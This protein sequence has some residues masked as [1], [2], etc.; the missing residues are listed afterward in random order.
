M[1]Q[2]HGAV[3]PSSLAIPLQQRLAVPAC[4]APAVC[5]AHPISSR[6]EDTVHTSARTPLFKTQGNVG[7]R[8]VG[9]EP[10]LPLPRAS[11]TRPGLAA[12]IPRGR[13][14][15]PPRGL[16]AGSEA[17]PS[18]ARHVCQSCSL[19]LGRWAP[20][21]VQTPVVAQA[22]AAAFRVQTT[23]PHTPKR[24]SLTPKHL[25]HGAALPGAQKSPQ[26]QPQGEAGPGQPGTA[27]AG[28]GPRSD[29]R[30]DLAGRRSLQPL[31][32]L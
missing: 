9:A 6:T 26:E 14:D 27:E 18:A 12:A 4:L 15:L 5:P 16:G 17:L 29:T 13:R 19:V 30:G 25:R 22:P 21:A 1:L 20:A 8:A 11:S 28:D 24:Q 3:E 7:A 10:R 23:T 2:L 31:Q 32:L